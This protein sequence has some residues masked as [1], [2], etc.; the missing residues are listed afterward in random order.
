[1]PASAA[2]RPARPPVG[3]GL[4]EGV[5]DAPPACGA[6]TARC[7]GQSKSHGRPC[8]PD[9]GTLGHRS[10]QSGSAGAAARRVARASACRTAIESKPKLHRLEAYCEVRPI[11]RC[12]VIS[13][14]RSDNPK[15]NLTRRANQGY[16]III[17]KTDKARAE[18]S[19]AGF[20]FD[21]IPI[22]R[23]PH[24]TTPHL[25]AR[26]Q[27]VVSAPPSEPISL[28]TISRHARTCRRAARPKG[29]CRTRPLIAGDMGCNSPVFPKPSGR[30][31]SQP[32][33]RRRA[34]GGSNRPI[35]QRFRAACASA[36]P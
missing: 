7:F 15:K 26:R 25:P 29:R 5:S 20:L 14:H 8:R 36:Q 28:V 21:E 13:R 23:R 24:V 4:S 27:S 18:K 32:A 35:P 3:L 11:A 16:N 9:R 6:G 31:A 1:M 17:A 22:G 12:F 30:N 10:R 2:I 19:A 33:S 34:C